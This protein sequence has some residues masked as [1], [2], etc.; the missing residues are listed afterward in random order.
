MMVFIASI[1]HTVLVCVHKSMMFTQL[2]SSLRMHFSGCVLVIKWHTTV[3]VFG[4]FINHILIVKNGE[5]I[6]GRVNPPIGS[7]GLQPSGAITGNGGSSPFW[8][9]NKYLDCW[10]LTLLQNIIFKCI[11]ENTKDCKG[12]QR[13]WNTPTGVLRQICAT[14]ILV[15]S[16]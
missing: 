8:A 10:S 3:S 11:K 15:F 12:D 7:W 13:C 1:C 16:H 2:P 4:L 6:H 5:T 14:V 9:M